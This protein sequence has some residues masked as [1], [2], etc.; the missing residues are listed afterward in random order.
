MFC[1]YLLGDKIPAGFQ[2]PE[3]LAFII[4]LVAVDDYVERGVVKGQG[5]VRSRRTP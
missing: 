1:P 5:V 3:H 4:R 2:H